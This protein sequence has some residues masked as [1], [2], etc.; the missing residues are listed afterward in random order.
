M[1]QIFSYQGYLAFRTRL[2]TLAKGIESDS[3]QQN[4]P[5]SKLLIISWNAQQDHCII[6]ES[7][8]DKAQ[9]ASDNCPMATTQATAT[10]NTGGNNAEFF[11]CSGSG[12][13]YR[14]TRDR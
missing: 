3:Q 11:A 7:N 12:V 14:K 10:D 13:C 9:K 6:D 2:P 1:N 8:K 4:D 5:H